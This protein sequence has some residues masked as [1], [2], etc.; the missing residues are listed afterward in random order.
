MGAFYEC[1]DCGY[2]QVSKFVVC[3]KCGED[4]CRMD[5]DEWDDHHPDPEPDCDEDDDE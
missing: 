2:A 4:D 3:P 5:F 1:L